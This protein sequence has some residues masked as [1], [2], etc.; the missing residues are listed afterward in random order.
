MIFR[1]SVFGSVLGLVVLTIGDPFLLSAVNGQCMSQTITDAADACLAET[2]CDKFC[3]QDQQPIMD[4]YNLWIWE[5]I[6]QATMDLADDDEFDDN[7]ETE[8]AEQFIETERNKY[9]EN[10]RGQ[11]DPNTGQCDS[12]LETAC[13]AKDCCPQCAHELQEY[14]DCEF[15][16]MDKEYMLSSIYGVQAW[17]EELL[18]CTCRAPTNAAAAAPAAPAAATAVATPAASTIMLFG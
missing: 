12:Y 17:P 5:G 1:P 14:Y 11:F 3:K 7:N 4:Q 13:F 15:E 6:W 16:A 10:T 9:D 18:E 2:A 8:A